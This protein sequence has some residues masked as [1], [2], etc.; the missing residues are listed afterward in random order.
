MFLIL[1]ANAK[2]Q[3]QKARECWHMAFCG[4][5]KTSQNE[6]QR[7]TT[8]TPIY[9]QRYSFFFCLP[10]ANV[11]G[12]KMFAEYNGEE[13]K[14]APKLRNRLKRLDTARITRKQNVTTI[15][16]VSFLFAQLKYVSVFC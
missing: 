15:F 13:S 4:L 2:T 1:I 3:A 14:G 8:T 12:K 16:T 6:P 5:R 11:E 9:T 7:E 10:N